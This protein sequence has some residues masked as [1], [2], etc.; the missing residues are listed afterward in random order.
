MSQSDDDHRY[1]TCPPLVWLRS[2]ILAPTKDCMPLSRSPPFIVHACLPG[3]FA[4]SFSAC[5]DI[6]LKFGVQMV[7]H[8]MP[9]QLLHHLKICKGPRSCGWHAWSKMGLTANLR[10]RA[11]RQPSIIVSWAGQQQVVLVGRDLLD[12]DKC[13]Q[14]P[15]TAGPAAAAIL[16]EGKMADHSVLI[17][18]WRMIS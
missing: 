8:P 9:F 2:S 12:W 7:C 13:V 18:T 1:I 4:P 6:T 14:I 11:F 5:W 15:V 17:G 10:W 3:L 16:S